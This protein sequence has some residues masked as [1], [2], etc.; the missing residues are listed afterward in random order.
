MFSVIFLTLAIL[1]FPTI[2][3]IT[4]SI[5][6]IKNKVNKKVNNIKNKAYALFLDDEFLTKKD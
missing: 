5:P 3:M 6:F 1:V 2:S 4:G